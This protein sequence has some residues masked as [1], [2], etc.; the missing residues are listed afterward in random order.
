MFYCK[1]RMTNAAAHPLGGGAAAQ[2]ERRPPQRRERKTRCAWAGRA[3]VENCGKMPKG[4]R[5][6][7]PSLG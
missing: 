2:R 7:A 6:K 5:L 4:P 3:V 1:S